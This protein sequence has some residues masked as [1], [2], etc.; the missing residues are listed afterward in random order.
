MA[1]LNLRKDAEE[2]FKHV[3]NT[4]DSQSLVKKKVSINGS[5]LLVD[6]REYD[7][8]NYEH[9]YVI[10]GGKAC[11]PMAKTIEEI[12]G[13]RLDDGIVV[14]KYD[15]GLPLKKIKTVEASHPIPDANGLEGTSEILR[16]LSNTS[17]KDLIICLISG[18]GS[19]LLVQPQKGITLEDIQVTSNALLACGATIDEI[20][21][22]RKHLSIVKGGHLA[23]ASYPST[24]ITLI[25]SDVIGDPLDIIASGPTVPDESTFDDA[26]KVIGNYSLENVI[27]GSVCN[28]LN[29]GQSGESEENPKHGDKVFTNTQNVIIG[30]NKIALEAAKEKAADLGY[31]T[32]IL[33]SMVQGESREAA[34]FFSSIAKEVYRTGIPVSKPACI[35]AGGETTVTIKGDGKGGRNQEFALSAAIDIEG[36]KGIVVLSAGTDGTDG[37]TDA[38]GAIVDY[39]T[40][41]DARERFYMKPEEILSNND[42]YNFFNKTGEHIITGPTLTNVMDIMISLI[43]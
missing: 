13:N 18:G 34:I 28:I 30:S 31:N 27:P 11:A 6:Q 33:S 19:A 24:L 26:C 37:P 35:I 5:T 15:H 21:A 20:N 23:W 3:L 10:G 29:K 36:Y 16:L 25:L 22:V 38:T 14:V 1:I 8:E 7:L 41:K 43:N 2:I 17:E 39:N 12:L 32:I 40:C 42:S 4:L 9:V